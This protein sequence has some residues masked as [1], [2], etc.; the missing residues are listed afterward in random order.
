[1]ADL[2]PLEIE[3]TEPVATNSETLVDN[4]VQEIGPTNKDT[5]IGVGTLFV[6][7]LLFFL[8]RNAY[9]NFLV[10]SLKR[11]PNTAGL[12]ASGLFGSLLFGSAI[13]CVA[14]VSRSLLTSE[15]IIPLAVLSILCLM[16]CVITSTKK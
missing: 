14:L 2:P 10:G 11:A 4:G 1:M 3:K 8:I 12:A 6:L 13:G 5:M 7:A 16:I 15:V 9:A